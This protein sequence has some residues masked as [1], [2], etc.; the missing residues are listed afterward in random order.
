[1][2]LLVALC[3]DRGSARM[4]TQLLANHSSNQK[5]QEPKDG[6]IPIAAPRAANVQPAIRKN[7]VGEFQAFSQGSGDS[8]VLDRSFEGSL[9]SLSGD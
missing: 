3:L 8:R 2:S 9:V 1:M 5:P 4:C 7:F 6:A